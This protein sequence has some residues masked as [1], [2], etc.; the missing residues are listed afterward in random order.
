MVTE[1]GELPSFGDNG[2]EVAGPT[3][4]EG[5]TANDFANMWQ[6][7]SEGDADALHS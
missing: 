5:Y 2:S 6:F 7:A 3:E 4:P 1:A